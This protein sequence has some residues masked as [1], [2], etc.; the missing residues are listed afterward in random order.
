LNS[1]QQSSLITEGTQRI[2]PPAP[3]TAG[4]FLNVA[5]YQNGIG[6]GAW[7]HF[8][9]WSE[10]LLSYIAASEGLTDGSQAGE[11]EEQAINEQ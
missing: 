7:T 5:N 8:D 3:A 1:F 6:Y 10:A 4:Y 11:G 2:T 9:G